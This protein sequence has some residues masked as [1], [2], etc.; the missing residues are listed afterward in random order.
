[1]TKNRIFVLINRV[2]LIVFHKISQMYEKELNNR[3]NIYRL[4]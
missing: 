3:L 1:L 2:V 4:E